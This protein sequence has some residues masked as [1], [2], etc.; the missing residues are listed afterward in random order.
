MKRFLKDTCKYVVV[1]ILVYGVL[2]VLSG[3][4]NCSNWSWIIKIMFAFG[5]FF[6]LESYKNLTIIGREP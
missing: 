5:A 6:A 2:S 3:N 4:F 1:L